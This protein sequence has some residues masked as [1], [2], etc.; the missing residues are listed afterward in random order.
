[1]ER[2]LDQPANRVKSIVSLIPEWSGKLLP[3]LP[4]EKNSLVGL[5]LCFIVDRA[6]DVERAKGSGRPALAGREKT[7]AG[8]DGDQ[9]IP[10]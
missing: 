3:S 8:G 10:A 6:G 7:V 4:Y 2:N 9:R 5:D 1:M